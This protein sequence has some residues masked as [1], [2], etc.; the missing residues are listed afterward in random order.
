MCDL[1]LKVP[2]CVPLVTGVAGAFLLVVNDEN[3]I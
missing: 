1:K 2:E 3:S